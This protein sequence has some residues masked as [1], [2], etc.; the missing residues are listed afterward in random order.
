MFH[1]IDLFLHE[2]LDVLLCRCNGHHICEDMS[3]EGN[4]T[5]NCSSSEFRCLAGV[6][7]LNGE[8]CVWHHYVCD[9]IADCTDGSDEAGCNYTCPVGAFRCS[10][11]TVADSQ[12]MHIGE[13][14]DCHE[15]A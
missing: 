2:M 8:K 3:D 4:C 5:T 9:R 14:C 15:F 13:L 1:Y 10:V 11:G 6:D 7:K 12:G